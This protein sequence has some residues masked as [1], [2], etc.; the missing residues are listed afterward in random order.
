M[1]RTVLASASP[2][3]LEVLRRAGIVPEVIVSG[4]DESTVRATTPTE[5]STELA[6]LK[7]RAVAIGHPEALVIGC[8][9][10]LEFDGQIFGKPATVDDARARWRAMRGA[11]GVLH[12]G[13][14]VRFKGHEVVR[15]VSTRV[16]FA[17]ITDAEL[18]SYLHTRE[19]LQVAGAF[20]IDGFGGA[21]IERIEGDH[22]NVIGLS[23]PTL[24]HMIID[25]GL[26][27][28]DLWTS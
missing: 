22:H 27:W 1:V 11:V 19:P 21:F 16:H 2:A 3:R 25:L 18:E 4:V 5:L 8:D 14:C 13:H 6:T 15:H 17:Q 7:C 23:L 9:S 24:R 26:G 10:V 20:T 28:P 12:T